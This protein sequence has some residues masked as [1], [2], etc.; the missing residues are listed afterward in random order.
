MSQNVDY[1]TTPPERPAGEALAPAAAAPPPRGSASV[2]AWE[3][4]PE[5]AGH[6]LAAAHAGSPA[7][8]AAYRR[9]LQAFCSGLDDGRVTPAGLTAYRARLLADGRGRATHRQALAAVRGFLSWSADLAQALGEAPPIPPEAVKRLL[10]APRG[11]VVRPYQVLDDREAAALLCHA[12]ADRDRAMLAV[13]LGGGLR[14][15]ELVGL[16]VAD[17]QRQGEAFALWVRHGKGG[18]SRT[19]PVRADVAGH[20]ADYL[21]ATGR[22]WSSPGPLFQALPPRGGRRRPGGRL[23]TRAVEHRLQRLLPL[24][25]LA[26]RAISPHALRHTYAMRYLRAGG[27]LKALQVLL[28]HASIETT[29]RYLRHL[30]LEEIRKGLPELPTSAYR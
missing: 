27:N 6:Y 25:G 17:V 29:E 3:E 10:R 8:V 7:T 20:L 30:E 12:P 5:L 15:A 2:Y 23:T 24:A 1:A 26:G 22:T 28:G 4:L 19:V 14:V 9:H 11:Q 13:F 18:K 21:T 16:D